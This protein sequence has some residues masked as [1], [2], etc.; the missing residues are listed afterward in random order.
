MLGFNESLG[1]IMA[2][3][4][5]KVGGRRGGFTLVELLVVIGII[6][7]L[8][9]ILLPALNRAREQ[10][11]RTKCLA[12]LHS[13]G[14]MINMYANAYKGNIPIGYS[15]GASGSGSMGS[16][17]YM[18]RANSNGVRFVGLGLLFPAGLIKESIGEGP[19][20]YCP[21]T[22]AETDH[23]FNTDDNPWIDTVIATGKDATRAAYS[24]RSSDPTSDRPVGQRGIMWGTAPGFAFLPQP[25]APCNGEAS[26]NPKMPALMMK[27]ARMKTRAIVSDLNI[28]TRV[29]VAHVRGL[30][31]LSADGSARYIDLKYIGY[32]P[33]GTVADPEH[34]TGPVDTTKWLQDDMTVASSD[35]KNRIIELWWARVDAAP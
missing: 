25:D 34:Y 27:L 22:N 16:N 30:N 29:K 13:I 3:H 20:F 1:G 9:S 19:L 17:Y 10:A 4:M 8:I 6:A 7:L 23:S 14:Q 18:A 33:A 35:Q 26:N 32:S 11:N 31:V 21:S 2:R 15:G 5:R 12:N 28:A 24:C